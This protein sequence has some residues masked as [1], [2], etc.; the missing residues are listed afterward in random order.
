MV[1]FFSDSFDRK[2]YESVEKKSKCVAM[3]GYGGQDS[4]LP[5]VTECK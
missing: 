2:Q 4:I 5:L 3:L 1:N